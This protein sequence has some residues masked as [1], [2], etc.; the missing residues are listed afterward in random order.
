MLITTL[1]ENRPSPHDPQLA[2]E[3]GLSL[4]VDLGGRRLLVDVGA[5]DA[6]ARNAAHLGIDI[7]SIDAAI[8]SHHHGD[9]GGGLARFFELNDHAP[10]YLGPAPEGEATVKLLGVVRRRIGLDPGVLAR[11]AHRLRVVRERT[12]VLP[13]A[14]V[15]PCAGGAHA[16]P[17]GN[18]LLFVRRK[19]RLVHDDFRH[20]VV[21]ALRE[22]DAMTVLTGCSHNGLVNMVEAVTAAFPGVPVKA[23]VGGFHLTRLPPFRGMDETE[24][25]VAG[26][27]RS[28][29]G[30]GVGTTYT[31]HCTGSKAFEA[32][33]RTMGERIREIH[34]GSRLEL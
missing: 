13:G 25:V 24:A 28:V 3:W 17:S 9:H 2:A 8:I 20:E 10:V 14:Y 19:G 4:C 21:V 29:L 15:L 34:T 16:R 1:V 12:E 11:H 31:G 5:S 32:L 22:G 23:V 18:R 7:A 27:G 26:I 33:R 6:F 30:L